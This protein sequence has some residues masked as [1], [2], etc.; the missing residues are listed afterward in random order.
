MSTQ[1]TNFGFILNLLTN[2]HTG[3]EWSTFFIQKIFRKS[4]KWFLKF[5]NAKL[6]SLFIM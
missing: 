4:I 5:I 2:I 1:E 6:S 3:I